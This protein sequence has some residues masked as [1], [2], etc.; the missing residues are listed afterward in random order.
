[1]QASH[2]PVGARR[3][4]RRKLLSARRTSMPLPGA[5]A[6]ENQ[7]FPENVSPVMRSGGVYKP[8]TAARRFFGRGRHVFVISDI[9]YRS[10]VDD[11]TRSAVDPIPRASI[12]VK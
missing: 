6:L 8:S 10:R 9:C 5:S 4:R 12:I 3:E 7:A 2:Y 1:M 11:I